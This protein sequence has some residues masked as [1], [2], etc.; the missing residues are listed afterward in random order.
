MFDT[1]T[2]TY[3]K[4][5][6]PTE[7]RLNVKDTFVETYSIP[8]EFTSLGFRYLIYFLFKSYVKDF[9][10]SGTISCL[11][12][13]IEPRMVTEIQGPVRWCPEVFFSDSIST[14]K[15]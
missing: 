10:V 15:G 3:T 6:H 12:D 5:K 2:V 13:M 8:L 11:R 14:T 1:W 9:K 4:Y 7:I